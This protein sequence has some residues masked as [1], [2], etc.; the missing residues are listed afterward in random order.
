MRPR[1]SWSSCMV[2]DKQRGSQAGRRAARSRRSPLQAAWGQD[3]N[4]RCSVHTQNWLAVRGLAM[5]YMRR[6]KD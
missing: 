3:R 1:R 5:L 4:Q 2:L 6:E